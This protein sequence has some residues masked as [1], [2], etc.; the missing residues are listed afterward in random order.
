MEI[1]R[2]KYIFILFNTAFF[3]LFATCQKEPDKP[4]GDNKVVLTSTTAGNPGYFSVSVYCSFAKA[5]GQSIT[6][7]GFCYA[8]TPDPDIN[9]SVKS[10][11]KHT[12]PSGFSAEISNLEDNKKYYIRAYASF[13]GGT[14]YSA[15]KEI[16]TLKSGKPRISTVAVSNITPAAAVCGGVIES[17]SGYAV[18]ASGICWDID[19]QF[20]EDQCLGKAVNTSGATSYIMNIEGLTEGTNYFVKAFATNQKGTGYGEISQFSTVPV[21]IPD[22]TT[23][24]IT[25]PTTNSATGGGNVP[26]SGNATVTAR[27]VCWNTTANPTLKNCLGFTTD[28]QGTGSFTSNITNLADGVKYYVVAYATNSKGTGYGAQVDF[29]TLPITL[30]TV[31]TSGIT[32]PTTNSA[33]GGGNVTDSGNATVTARGVC[34]NT[35]GNPTLQNCISFT[36]NGSGTGPFISS[37]TG[38]SDGVTYFVKAYATNVEGTTYGTQVNFTTLAITLPTVTTTAITNPT[39]NSATGGGN[40]TNAGN[41]TVTARGVCWNT[42]GNPT[43]Q[44]CINFTSDGIGIGSF[45]SNITGLSPSTTYFVRAYATNSEGTAYDVDDVSFTTLTPWSCGATLGITHTA[46]AI[47]PVNKTVNYGTVQ[48]NLTGSNKCWITQNL[49]ADHQATSATDA[50]EASAG[51]YWQ[52]N[53]KQGYKH[54]GTTRTPSTTWISSINENSDWL[55]ANDPCALLL[56]SGWRLP[57]NTEW[58]NADET[59]GW[60]NYNQTFASVLKLHAAGYL[61]NSSGSLNYRGSLGFYWSSSQFDS[62]TGRYLTFGSGGSYMPTNGKA[63]GFSAR[64]LRD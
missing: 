31:I 62:Y 32:N 4:T 60:D 28:G 43:L 24:N 57:T 46:G 7:H 54:D 42:T 40:V 9:A 55:P 51:W 17:D 36:A 26:N 61:Y 29:T 18:T 35:T 50:T 45:T 8:T 63:Y 41:A 15:H 33:T 38:L 19:N 48:T 49:G 53:R 22:V 47:A 58:T 27:G 20:N 21:A 14:I 13:A 11:G 16:T 37:I 5:S 25:N 39:T 56:G 1:M 10:L 59:G 2:Q 3:L 23:A 30:P 44:N 6:D 34:W 12:G 64:C 52:F